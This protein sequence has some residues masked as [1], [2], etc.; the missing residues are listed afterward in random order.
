MSNQLFGKLGER[1]A[2][3]VGADIVDRERLDAKVGLARRLVSEQPDNA[4][5]AL[6]LMLSEDALRKASPEAEAAA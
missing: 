1:D 3:A 4:V 2:A 6:R 5:A